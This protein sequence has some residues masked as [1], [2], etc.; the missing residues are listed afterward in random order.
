M[1]EWRDLAEKT[2]YNRG[3]AASSGSILPAETADNTGSYEAWMVR[4]LKFVF[5]L[6]LLV[7]LGVVGFAY[8]GDLDPQREDISVPVELD[9]AG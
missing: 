1:P 5:F 8:L 3:K 4:L 7:A 9:D 2:I 6:A